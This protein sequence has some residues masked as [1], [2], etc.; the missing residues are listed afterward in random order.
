MAWTTSILVARPS[1]RKRTACLCYD[2][3]ETCLSSETAALTISNEK[4]SCGNAPG[5]TWRQHHG[6][7]GGETP[8]HRCHPLFMPCCQKGAY[9]NLDRKY[10]IHSQRS[11]Y[12]QTQILSKQSEMV[13]LTYYLH[14]I[15]GL[16]L[17]TE[18]YYVTCWRRACGHRT[19]P[20]Q[21]HQ[22][23]RIKSIFYK[24]ACLVD[25]HKAF[26]LGIVASD[27]VHLVTCLGSTQRKR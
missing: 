27:K 2:R 8:S 3:T 13:L 4:Y 24:R 9:K 11:L 5:L 1:V 17:T 22:K 21:E 18:E 26:S 20:R 10:I 12:F 19:S 16:L 6:A 25:A 23:H 15:E 7:Q 14:S